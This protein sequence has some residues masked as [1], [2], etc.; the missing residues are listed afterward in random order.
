MPTASQPSKPSLFLDA[1]ALFAAIFSETGG[2]R[3]LLKL[4]EGGLIDLVVSHQVLAEVEG[5]LRRKAPAALGHMALLLNRARCRTM[6]N[7]PQDKVAP[8]LAHILYAPDA[9]VFAAAVIAQA[10]YF[11]TLDRQHLL[12]NSALEAASPLPIGTPGDALAW[13]RGTFIPDGGANLLGR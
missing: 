3:M 12:G 1:S 4:G 11:V 6:P 8:W 13:L 7:P 9:A 10:D 5:A 2:A